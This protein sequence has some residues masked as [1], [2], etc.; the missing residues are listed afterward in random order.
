[1]PIIRVAVPQWEP[2][3]FDKAATTQRVVELIKEAADGGAKLVAFGELVRIIVIGAGFGAD[4]SGH[5][6]ISHLPVR[7]TN[8]RHL[9]A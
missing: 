6:W 9:C 8:G 2:A 3:W 1:M 7:W 5:P 4:K